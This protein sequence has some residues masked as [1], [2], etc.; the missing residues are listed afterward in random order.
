MQITG[1][2]DQACIWLLL[3]KL[4]LK[5]QPVGIFCSIR[6]VPTQEYNRN[7]LI[8]VVT[9]VY[10]LPS[11]SVFLKKYFCITFRWIMFSKTVLSNFK[12]RSVHNF[13][14]PAEFENSKRT[15]GLHAVICLYTSLLSFK[16]IRQQKLVGTSE[17][18]YVRISNKAFSE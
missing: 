17:T 1:L 5:N 2:P 16:E 18:L 14:Q 12:K 6:I 8:K 9:I 3:A 11:T 4:I 7:L 15:E 13:K 10:N